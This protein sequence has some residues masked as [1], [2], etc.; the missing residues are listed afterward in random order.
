LALAAL[1][2]GG[3]LNQAGL[4][5]ASLT[6]RLADIAGLTT[7][8]DVRGVLITEANFSILERLAHWQAAAAMAEAHPWLGVGLGNYSA[9]YPAY[10]LLNWPNALGHAHMIYLNVVAETGVI[11]LMAYLFLWIVIFGSTLHVIG[12]AHGV[13]RGL[14]LGLLGTWAHFSAHQVFDNLYVNNIHLTL[15]A[16]LALL[17]F[18]ANTTYSTRPS[19][20]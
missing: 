19:T 13:Q 7:L 5:P 12:R 2:G 10:Q 8:T 14:A 3:A 1:G 6:S 17:V 18:T 20:Q 15:G 4:L 11:G 16:L 9:A